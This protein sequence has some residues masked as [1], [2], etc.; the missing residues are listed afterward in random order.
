M[1]SVLFLLTLWLFA[2]LGSRLSAQADI[3]ADYAAIIG[4][5]AGTVSDGY[6]SPG[7]I[8]TFGRASFP[9]L[10]DGDAA[11][12]LAA[13]RY[14]NGVS[15]TAARAVA[16]AH[17]GFFSTDGS[18]TSQLFVN[19]ILWASRKASPGLVRVG[20]TDSGLRT[21]LQGQG[22]LTKAISTSMSN[23]T[24]DL[25]TCDVFVG[26]FHS[27]FSAGAITKIQ[28]F[29]AAGGGLVVCSTPWALSTQ[30]FNDA[31]L[32]LEPFGLAMSG[33]GTSSSTF[34]VAASPLPTFHS[35]LLGIDRMIDESVNGVPFALADERIAA[36]SVDRTLAV[37]PQQ[38]GILAA[39][40]ALEPSYGTI[41]V[42]AAAPLVKANQPVHAMLA[43]Y[44]S[45]RY[46]SMPASQ[47]FVHPSS[48]DW[49]GSPAPGGT[50]VTR[51]ITVNGNVP[52]D[53]YINWGD[54]GRRYDT[55]LY[56]AP[57]ATI[58][59]DIP[60][61]KVAGGV[62]VDIG[63]HIDVNFHLDQ[64][65]RFPKV[66]R[67]VPLTQTSTATGNV[68]GGLIWI[69]VPAG[70]NLGTFNV[71]ISGALEAP[72]FQLG[73][74]TDATWN[75]TLKN[76]PGAW[77]CIMTDNVAAYG[78]TPAFTVYVSRNQLQNVTSAEAVAQH[79]KEVIETADDLMGYTAHRKRGESALSDR[80]IL[81]GY[82]HAG[83]PVMMAYGDSSSLVDA[84]VKGGDWGFYH[85]IGHTYQDSYDGTYGIAT[86][87]EVD[88]NLVPALLYTHVHDRTCWDGDVH[89][90]FNGGNRLS[91]RQL[92][93]G[94]PAVDQTWSYA[95]SDGA[96]AYDF[97]F[98]LAEAFGWE[99]YR[100][101]LSR[102]IAWHKGG[103]DAGLSALSY[104][105]DSD[106]DRRDRFYVIFCDA[107]GRNLDAYFQQY[108]LG[109]A[110]RGYEISADAK[111]QIA[112]KGYPTWTA[113]TA[114][115]SISPPP[116][117]DLP[118]GTAP[119]TQ[120][121]TLQANDPEEPGTIWNWSIVSGNNGGNFV[122]DRRSGQLAVAATGLDFETATSYT[123]TVRAE[124]GGV[125]RYSVDR[126]VLIDIDNLV[127]GPRQ[128][129]WAVFSAT[130]TM[131]SGTVLGPGITADA[132]R[133]LSS[134]AILSG[135]ASGAFAL[136]A[137]GRVILQNPAALPTASVVTLVIRG[138]D[139]A[140]ITGYSTVRILS[141]TAT[142]LR[143][144]RWSGQTNFN[145]NTW[146]GS[147]NFSGTLATSTSAQN[148]G[149]S[150]SRRVTGWLIA[151][152]TGNYTFWVSSDDGS[153]FYL[154]TD[155]TSE[156]RV[157]IASLATW[158]SFQNFDAESSQQSV[159]IPLIAGRAY[160]FEAQQAEGSGSD[161]VAVA[162]LRPGQTTREIIPSSWLIPNVTGI[163]AN[164]VAAVPSA[165]V[166]DD[167]SFSIAENSSTSTVL[168]TLVATD[169]DAGDTLNYG[170][171]SGNGAG[172]FSLHPATG[173]LSLAATPDHEAAS[174][175]TLVITVTD[176]IGMSD[177]AAVT[178]TVT[179]VNDP[180][181]MAQSVFDLG[182][183]PEDEAFSGLLSASDPDAGDTLTFSK[184]NGPTWLQV[185]T[186]GT[187][188]GTPGN[189]DVGPAQGLV[190][191]TDSSGAS[192]E[193]DL[194]LEVV[195]RNDPPAFTS[196]TFSLG[197]TEDEAITGNLSATDIDAGDLLTFTKSSGPAWLQIASNGSLGGTPGNADVGLNAFE[198]TVTDAAGATDTA[199]L[200]ITVAAVN[201]AP[202]F[203]T[204]PVTRESA[205]EGE[206]YTGTSLAGT[207]VDA[208]AGDAL[209]YSK[210]AGPGWLSIAADGTL[211]GTPPE[212]SAGS[213][214]FTI[215]AT[216]LAGAF[217]EA[218]LTFT[219]EGLPLPW[220]SAD[221]GTDIPQGSVSHASGSFTQSGAG[222]LAGRADRMRFT[223]QAISGNGELTA[224]ISNIQDTGN[225]SRVGVMVRESLATDSRH[226]FMGLSGTGTY[227][228]VR[229]TSNGSSTS[230]TQSGTGTLPDAW[231]R[232]RRSG[233][234]IT[235]FRSSDGIQWNTVGSVSV[236]MSPNCYIG[237]VVA[238]GST[239]VL[240]TSTFSQVSFTP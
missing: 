17:T 91:T 84:T 193:A 127:E 154:G 192:A 99:T 150:Y 148:V 22:F 165:P 1:K 166:I 131:A 93:Q 164:S 2:G 213:Q 114:V 138:T 201:D 145:N 135:N 53:S 88:V 163:T 85:E 18:T 15:A 63:C 188:S 39:L 14:G 225:A 205:L 210:V 30:A 60:A 175:H 161:H 234:T 104:A 171:S 202:V 162:W 6:G 80:D 147:T 7:S 28:T 13:G 198:I 182:D 207:A 181:V 96:T 216:D 119:G 68:F 179:N 115:D 156:S 237:L 112:A 185:A 42:T 124:D 66:T 233:N 21:F 75:S 27:G 120:V 82:G 208:D 32:V 223:Y 61:D 229:R 49:P 228:W 143:E 97:Y 194:L 52:T 78:N 19:S 134:T 8:A 43:R 16:G 11:P 173:V 152:T 129:G 140:G 230:T 118:E 62:R 190:R 59:V 113:N 10:I 167:Q 116:P 191:V 122:I 110:G 180:P 226:V 128:S 159:S 23:S 51:T 31:L 58:T 87:G 132:T 238:S 117:L 217:D 71:T 98:N 25:S 95:C 76:L 73:V 177:S 45:S 197:A 3:P 204:D 133:S 107:T 83:Y 153:R 69:N 155:S 70:A 146:T 172:L 41:T 47:L 79:W 64:W 144:Q 200:Q 48:S 227:R 189:S 94:R 67:S 90:T 9:V 224:R 50:T 44:Q 35:A 214:S 136:D 123:L 130:T 33:S 187:L 121:T 151:P 139:S 176:A 46:D 56:A 111:S 157:L 92:F 222:Q 211:S 55:R 72:S 209:S 57:G 89:S 65:N 20:S 77:G 5:T 195:N 212:G 12:A 219:V 158:T 4:S 102:L 169:T 81:A 26:N 106:Q 105:G 186:D 37:L 199:M 34:T 170:I 239:D 29:A 137:Q 174:S 240:N 178:I 126:T 218:Q 24:N 54:R 40:A 103:T 108:G 231:I 215:R 220:V 36:A 142:G 206:P 235:T 196:E 232:I 183:A 160:W 100:S 236:A 101:A 125:P 149:S 74:D 184:V 38:A 86:H 109:V 221:I 168:G 203:L 141:R